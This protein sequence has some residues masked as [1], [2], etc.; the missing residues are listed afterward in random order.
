MPTKTTKAK[1]RA[2]GPKVT[3][4]RPVVD[5]GRSYSHTALMAALGIGRQTLGEAVRDG[6]LKPVR[7]GR[8]VFFSGA[9]VV[10]WVDRVAR[11]LGP[12]G[13]LTIKANENNGVE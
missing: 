8:R 5:A 1:P 13:V 3:K 10:D 12:V 2:T 7:I 6:W 11:G 9:Q 4:R